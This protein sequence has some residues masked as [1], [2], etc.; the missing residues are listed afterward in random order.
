M[1]NSGQ[2]ANVPNPRPRFT[3]SWAGDTAS[4]VVQ[5][6]WTVAALGST[7]VELSAALRP[8]RRLNLDL[9]QI[10]R[11]DTAGALSLAR[12]AANRFNS[13]TLNARPEIARLLILVSHTLQ[14]SHPRRHAPG[15]LHALL[16]SLGR[17]ATLFA[18]ELVETL[19]FVGHVISALAGC[20]LDPRRIRWPAWFSQAERAGLDAMPI[21][22]TTS[23]FIGAVV[24]VLG[25]H[26]L[27]RFG[28]QVMA[29]ELIGVGVLREFGV[30]ITGVL[31]AGRSASAFAA[32]L[33]A[34]RMQQEIDALRVMGIDPVEALVLP[35]LGALLATMPLLTFVAMMAGLSG[36]I[37]TIWTSLGLA[38]PFFLERMIESVGVTHFWVGISK[39]PIMAIVV[40]AIGCHQGLKVGGDVESLGRR[41][42]AAVV[43]AIFA[44]IMID[45]AFALMFTELDI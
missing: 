19:T 2:E 13:D 21:V 14:D 27:R 15:D 12:V 23:F 5:G 22:A 41:V 8:A 7:T 39:A 34:M 24:G 20:A 6:D 43:H 26:M 38:P 30:V 17:G 35:R 33:G 31:L 1:V 28:A 32:E 4:V 45:A 10:G 42:T 9:T 18:L 40:A 16:V 11:V 29:V 36:G 25:V 44:V 37:L 3:L